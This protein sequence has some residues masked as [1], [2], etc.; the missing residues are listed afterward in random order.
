MSVALSRITPYLNDDIV[1]VI[2]L[3]LTAAL[4]FMVESRQSGTK[5]L[6]ASDAD[7]GSGRLLGRLWRVA[8]VIAVLAI[9]FLPNASIRS[10]PAVVFWI[11]IALVW[12]G[13]GL[14]F[15]AFATLGRYFTFNVMTSPGQEIIASGPYRLLRHPSYA[16]STLALAAFGLAMGNWVSFGALLVLPLIGTVNRIRVEEAALTAA[17]GKPYQSFSAGRKRLVPFVW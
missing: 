14:R 8:L 3:C 5:R 9:V 16:G 13:I 1:A 11:A 7:S 4:W 6:E 12:C 10:N 15:W 17:V 2:V